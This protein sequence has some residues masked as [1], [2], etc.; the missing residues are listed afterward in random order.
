MGAC[1]WYTGAAEK[2]MMAMAAAV[3]A[4]P[5]GRRPGSGPSYIS[6]LL[7]HS[8]PS[9][10]VGAVQQVRHLGF[11]AGRQPV[12]PQH[13]EAAAGGRGRG[14]LARLGRLSGSRLVA[15]L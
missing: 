7:I 6:I 14:G 2:V 8:P 9:E 3:P 10:G 11:G 5:Q 12:A 15:A 13:I 4:V 1:W